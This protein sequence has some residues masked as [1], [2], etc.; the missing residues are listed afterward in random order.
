[1]TTVSFKKIGDGFPACKPVARFVTVLAMISNDWQ[2]SFEEMS[3][4]NDEDPEAGAR[5]MM[6]FRQ[7]AALHYEAA[8]FVAD[9][10]HNYDEIEE[11]IAALPEEAQDECSQVTDGIKAGS[12]VGEWLRNHRY[13]TFHYP[14]MHPA[15]AER[16]EE[17]IKKAL[18]A[19]AEEPGTIFI[20]DDMGSV[21][22]WFADEVARHWVPNDTPE[23][24]ARVIALRESMLALAQ[25]AQR[26]FAAYSGLRPSGTFVEGP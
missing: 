15:K 23:Q 22:F 19:A 17:E 26:A 1:M 12:D 20:G 4:V 5:R 13:V 6:L 7:Q 24:V 3:S 10:R 8:K 16:G 21:R 25:F 9:A 11:F 14:E 2:R 18:E